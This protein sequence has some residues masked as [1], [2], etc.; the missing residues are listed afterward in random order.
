MADNLRAGT[1]PNHFVVSEYEASGYRMKLREKILRE[2]E[3]V[4]AKPGTKRDDICWRHI[5]YRCW[6]GVDC[7]F[8]HPTLCESLI[9]GT[10]CGTGKELCNLYHPQIYYNYLRYKVCKW[11]GRCK[12]RDTDNMQGRRDDRNYVQSNGRHL[13]KRESDNPNSCRNYNTNIKHINEYRGY[14]NHPNSHLGS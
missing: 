2:M 5:N 12:F 4:S 3:K 14:G 13:K 11:G 1:N 9:N 8:K 6:R 10:S 7:L